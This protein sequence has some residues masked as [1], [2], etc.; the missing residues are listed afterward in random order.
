MGRRWACGWVLLVALATTAGCSQVLGIDD[1]TAGGSDDDAGVPPGDAPPGAADAGP[2]AAACNDQTDLA[3]DR[4]HCGRCDHACGGGDCA[5]GEC[6]PVPLTPE[7]TDLRKFAV[8]ADAIY[9]T[10]ETRVASCPLPVGCTLAPRNVGDP[11]DNLG[12]I[13][14]HGGTVYFSGCTFGAQSCDDYARLF[15]CPV[16][17]CSLPNQTA[18][19]TPNQFLRIVGAGA[20]LY[21]PDVAYG[22]H[23]CETAS[24]S[25]SHVLWQNTPIFGGAVTG[26]AVDATT[27]YVTTEVGMRTCP[28]ASGCATPAVID[29]TTGIQPPFAAHDG[30]VY[31]SRVGAPGQIRIQRCTLAACTAVDVANEAVGVT[32]ILADASGVYWVN[33]T[34]MTIRHCPIDGCPPGGAGYVARKLPDVVGLTLG[35]GFVYFRRNNR[36]Y[37]I[38][39][40]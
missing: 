19:T 26:L 14:V 24:C 36:I 17:G 39:K 40:P 6:Q 29:G 21:A 7:I 18:F 22:V 2:D 25:A 15:E 37:K 28:L 12:E 23:G 20:R 33:P 10:A 27:A 8:A 32:D 35:D 11:F 38:A 3:T 13:G 31:W 1:P 30:V 9:W 34:A 16:A 5:A 4:D